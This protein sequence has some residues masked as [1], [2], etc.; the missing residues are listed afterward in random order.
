MVLVWETMNWD[1]STT[2]SLNNDF[3][4]RYNFMNLIADLSDKANLISLISE[5]TN[6]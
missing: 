6:K 3:K 5:M 1:D 4:C 2:L